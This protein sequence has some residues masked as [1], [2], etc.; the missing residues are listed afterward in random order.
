MSTDDA[1]GLD[2][3]LAQAHHFLDPATGAVV[4]PLQPSTTFARDAAYELM[5]DYLYARGHNPTTD[6]L[7]HLLAELEGGAEAR[8]FASGMAAATTVL[9]TVRTGEHIVAPT[10]MYHGIKNWLGRLATTRGIEV[11]FV[12]ATDPSALRAAIRPGSTA[13]VWVEPVLNPTCDVVDVAATAQT[14]HAAGAALVVDATF[15]PP[16]TLRALDLGA[17]I[18]M[19]SATKYLNG[20]SDV[21][22]GVLVTRHQDERWAEV[23]QVR[24]LLGGVLGPFE[25]WLVLRGLRT[26]ALRYARASAS[27]LSLAR[28]FD[29]HPRLEAVLYPGLPDHPGHEVAAR[30]MHGGFGGMLALLVRGGAEAAHQVAGRLQLF[31]RATSLGGVESLVEHRAAVEGPD[32]S[33]PP[34]LLRLSIGIEDPADLIADLEHAL[35]GW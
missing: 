34:H 33:V 2:S 21:L 12:D 8:T 28:H 13:L 6:V 16:V 14:A 3:L 31:V 29:G 30:Q 20:H 11:S 10:M 27:A 7:E 32:S 9:E 24:N 19:H 35:G 17:D 5:G 18:V 26:L 22:A 15:T 4:P 23:N 1:P 25:A